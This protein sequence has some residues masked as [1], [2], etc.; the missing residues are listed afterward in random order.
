MEGSLEPEPA[1]ALPQLR[2]SDRVTSSRRLWTL[3]TLFAFLFASVLSSPF[4][5]APAQAA[6]LAPVASDQSEST[7]E[8]T[9]LPIFLS[10]SDDDFDTLT[11]TLVDLP[12][13]G[14]LDGCS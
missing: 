12:A 13:H 6:G 4:S 1:V 2:Q 5:P 8:E 10:A 11:Y 9:D 14:T 3:A 7:R